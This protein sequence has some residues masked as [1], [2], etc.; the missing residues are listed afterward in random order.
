MVFRDDRDALLAQADA[1]RTQLADAE[2]KLEEARRIAADAQA[3]GI[4]DAEDPDEARLRKEIDRLRDQVDSLRE[5]NAN[6]RGDV[7]P[8]DVAPPPETERPPPLPELEP[9]PLVVSLPMPP[10]RDVPLPVLNPVAEVFGSVIRGPAPDL[11]PPGNPL[12]AVVAV[13]L[14]VAVALGFLLLALS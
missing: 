1:L 2:T 11:P 6:L 5:T 12:M 14:I 13:A 9:P 3:A 10:L 7:I 8:V 4:G